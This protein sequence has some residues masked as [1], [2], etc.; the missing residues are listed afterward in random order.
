[1]APNERARKEPRRAF[2]GHVSTLAV[3][4]PE[5][6]EIFDNFAFDEVLRARRAGR[7]DPADGPARSD[8]CLPGPARVP[9]HA[10]RGARR[11]GYAG[12]DQGD[13]VPG[14]AVR[15]HG[16]GLRLHPR[17]QRGAHRARHRACPCRAS[18]RPRRRTARRKAWRSRSRSSAATVVEKALCL[19]TGRPAAHPALPVG[20]LL[21]R[22]LHAH[23]HRRADTR[24]AHLQHACLRSVDA[25]RRSRAMSPRISTSATTARG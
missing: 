16:Q 12:R 5:L 2:P 9:R 8:H 11:R 21:R 10:R 13:R 3:T 18:P 4:D 19:R 25:T 15:R 20:Q 23:R 6:I 1:M 14:G 7:A 24:V 17:H 22:P